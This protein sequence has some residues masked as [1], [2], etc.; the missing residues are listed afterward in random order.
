VQQIVPGIPWRLGNPLSWEVVVTK[1]SKIY[2]YRGTEDPAQR[3]EVHRIWV[4]DPK[5]NESTETAYTATGG[6]W[7]GQTW[8]RDGNTIYLSTVNGELYK[9]DVGTEVFTYLGYFLPWEEYAAGGEST[10][11]SALPCRPMRNGSTVSP[12]EAVRAPQICMLMRSTRARSRWS[13]KW[14]QVSTLAA[15]CGIRGAISTLPGSTASLGKVKRALPS[16][17]TDGCF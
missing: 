3:D 4:Y 17:A 11:C 6:F 7:N 1:K 13:G 2:T 16:S 10:T 15:T 12:A 9:L 8:T 14:S 5:T